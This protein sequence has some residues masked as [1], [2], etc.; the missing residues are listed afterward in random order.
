MEREV[1]LI[2]VLLQFTALRPPYAARYPHFWEKYPH[3]WPIFILP[4]QIRRA[5]L[6]P[7]RA[8]KQVEFQRIQP[9]SK[10]LPERVSL[11]RQTSLLIA[12]DC[13]CVWGWSRRSKVAFQS[14][15]LPDKHV[16]FDANVSSSTGSTN[17]SREEVSA[18]KLTWRHISGFISQ[19]A[20]V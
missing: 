5:V 13:N 2:D 8:C 20:H 10:E 14:W 18:L 16:V 6:K 12:A 17:G 3:L 11:K 1:H 7:R 4:A 15:N 9:E 19:C